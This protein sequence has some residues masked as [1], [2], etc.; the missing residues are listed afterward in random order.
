[1]TQHVNWVAELAASNGAAF[2]AAEECRFASV[3]HDLGKYGMRFQG[4]LHGTEKHIDHWSAGAWEAALLSP[5][6]VA[7]ALAIQGHHIGLQRGDRDSIADLNVQDLLKSHPL[8]CVLSDDDHEAIKSRAQ[9]DGFT[10]SAPSASCFEWAVRDSDPVGQMLAVRMLFSAL[11]DA[12]FIA[13]E[14]HFE[15]LSVSGQ[16]RSAMTLD[17]GA[18]H[19]SLHSYIRKLTGNSKAAAEANAVRSALLKRC[20]A[21]GRGPQGLFTLNAPTG[22]GKTLAM[23]AWALEHCRTHS[24]LS[25]IIVVL[26]YLTIME[27]T[28]Q[29]YRESLAGWLPEQLRSRA[30]LEHHSLASWKS[31]QPARQPDD[32]QDRTG[33]HVRFLAENWDAPI[34]VTSTVQFF[35]SLFANSPSACRKLHRIANSVILLDEVQTLNTSLILPTLGAISTLTRRFG[36]SA[37]LA[38]ATQ[39][40][41]SH[42]AQRVEGIAAAGYAAEP[43]VAEPAPMFA[44]MRRTRVN[45]PAQYETSTWDEIADLMAKGGQA[46]CIVNLKR[47]AQGLFDVLRQRET[48]G[49]LHLS[50]SMC[51]DHRAQVLKE[52]GQRLDG[53]LPCLLVATQC[54]EAGV[55]LDFPLVMR[56]FGPLDSIAQAAGRCNR[57]GNRA[58]GEVR[59][60]R[61]DDSGRLYPDGAYEQA[62][63]V[64]AEL[65]QRRGGTLDIDDPLTFTEYFKSL[66]D[67]SRVESRNPEL[68]NAIGML[69]FVNVA[70]LYKVIDSGTISVVTPWAPDTFKKLAA[71]VRDGRLTRGWIQRSHGLTVNIFRPP[72]GAPEWSHLEPVRVGPDQTAVDWFLLND[73][74]DYD[75]FAGVR[76]QK[77]LALMEG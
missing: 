64:T 27:Q 71:E 28:A 6:G 73:P 66:Y 55:D 5:K 76:L 62:A 8:G 12:D 30:I 2:G 47:H 75:A 34:I 59:V 13:T 38:T 40:A 54:V 24:S 68:L 35:E 43:I 56:S 51:P 72:P 46:L 60:F 41:F 69:D 48:G 65:L 58:S 7:A 52:V 3:L 61:P 33:S 4:R 32:E 20:V 15:G 77:G 50:T 16:R 14:R 67:L 22:S 10:W 39:P 53:G 18:A 21:S 37:V 45:W 26:P 42:L 63:M 11:V 9:A 23:L 57:N 49:I 74:G 25:R 19:A 31:I 29:V 36:C 44:A 1:M 17:A 70:K